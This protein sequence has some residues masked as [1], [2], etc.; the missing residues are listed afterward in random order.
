MHIL[1]AEDDALLA[2][3]LTRFLTRVGHVTELAT[4]GKVA[5]DLLKRGHTVDALILDLGLP[6]YDGLTVLRHLRARGDNTPVL[7]LTARGQLSE[8]VA[9]LD[10]GADD[11]LTKPFDL[12]EVSARLRALGRRARGQVNNQ[13]LIGGLEIDPIGKR[14]WRDGEEVALTGREFAV[15]LALAERCQRWVTRSQLEILVYGNHATPESNAIEVYVSGLRRKLGS[16]FVHTER[17]LGWRLEDRRE[18]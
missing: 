9:G 11:Y 2:N 6:I 8:R 10:A 15:L 14:C 18:D 12:E 3:A 1:I 13:L 4:D 5:L 7:V 16:G 17:G